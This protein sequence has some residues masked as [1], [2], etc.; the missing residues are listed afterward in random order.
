M[1]K[2]TRQRIRRMLRARPRLR[3]RQKL[4][5]VRRHATRAKRDAFKLGRSLRRAYRNGRAR[6]R[7]LRK[8]LLSDRMRR[9]VMMRAHLLRSG[10]RY[11]YAGIEV[12]LPPDA[13]LE[14]RYDVARGRYE[15]HERHLIAHHLPPGLPVIELGGSLGLVSAFIGS[16]LDPGVPMVIVE[17][18][19][20]LIGYCRANAPRGGGER[21]IEIVNAA[22]AYG[23]A[24][25]EFWV[26]RNT[27]GSRLAPEGVSE[28]DKVRVPAVSLAELAARFAGD[29]SL[30]A[31]IEGAEFDLFEREREAL[32]RC[33]FAIVEHHPKVFAEQ[34]RAPERFM[35]L[36]AEA[37]FEIVEERH[38]CLVLARKASGRR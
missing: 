6:F 10:G 25:V 13:A 4:R 29:Y 28:R 24:A 36:V 32:R 7:D 31:D 15:R 5:I 17:A 33:A 34:G 16:R 19:P 21:P 2:A 1:R 30:V 37:G 14:L 22:L 18:N 3:L 38:N 26:H 9:Q 23:G 20:A 35:A 8:R 11:R 12:D 27:L